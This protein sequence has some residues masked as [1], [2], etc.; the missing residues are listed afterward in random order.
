MNRNIK[1]ILAAFCAAV[2]MVSSFAAC[3]A[4]VDVDSNGAATMQDY[5]VTVN[6]V[7]IN[8][9]PSKVVVLNAGYTDAI[10]A[11]GYETSLAAVTPDCTQ[12]DFS[13]LQKVDADDSNAILGLTPDLVISDV[14]DEGLKAKLKEGGINFVEITPARNREDYERMMSQLGSLVGGASNGYNKGLETAQSI[15][16]SLDDLSRVIPDNGKVVT[17]CYIYDTQ[18]KAVTGDSLSST[19]MSYAG[20][21]NIFKGVKGGTYDFENLKIMDPNFIFCPAG[22][23]DQITADTKFAKLSAVK[24]G[25]VYE[26]EPSMAEWYGRTIVTYATTIAGY[27]YPQLLEENTPTVS[28]T[29]GKDDKKEESSEAADKK[30]TEKDD[31]KDDKKNDEVLEAPVIEKTIVEGAAD[32]AVLV[33][34]KRLDQLGY[35]DSEYDGFFGA[36]TT[37]AIK[38]FQKANGLKDNGNINANTVEKLFS[39]DAVPAK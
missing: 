34:Q 38:E 29:T 7:T 27:A 18:G 8:S 31:K 33:V 28:M 1:K 15:F 39:E 16:T 3:S 4:P 6:E 10:L 11:M 14:I 5:P 37:K 21:T 13:T 19:V 12:N 2:L 20:I 23:K 30:D 17:G 26:V 24:N 36:V 9:K 22:V 35:L 32:E 25:H